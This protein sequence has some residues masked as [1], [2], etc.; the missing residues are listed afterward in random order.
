MY[1]YGSV[2]LS[3]SIRRYRIHQMIIDVST[4]YSSIISKYN[5]S[6]H[7]LLEVHW[8]F[9]GISCGGREYVG[10]FLRDLRAKKHPHTLPITAIPNEPHWNLARGDIHWGAFSL[11]AVGELFRQGEPYNFLRD[12]HSTFSFSFFSYPIEVLTMIVIKSSLID[13]G[14]TLIQ[15]LFTRRSVFRLDFDISFF[16]HILKNLQFRK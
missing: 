6:K 11:G 15:S 3:P 1:V 16:P 5:Q 8:G 13:L 4:Y 9:T 10:V 7:T 2:V 12:I 14:G